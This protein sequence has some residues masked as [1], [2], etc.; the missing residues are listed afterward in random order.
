MGLGRGA[1]E[2]S[3]LAAETAGRKQL[4]TEA[5]LNEGEEQRAQRL[6]RAEE[7]A[8]VRQHVK[9]M[10]RAFYC[11]VRLSHDAHVVV[12]ATRGHLVDAF[13]LFFRLGANCWVEGVPWLQVPL[14]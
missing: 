6:Q 7:H 13:L 3:L 8:R 11:E 5:Q 12:M 14:K 9:D 1:Q 10:Q 2:E 4:A